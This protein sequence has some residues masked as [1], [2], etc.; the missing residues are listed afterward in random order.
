MQARASK[1]EKEG[2][3][4][5]LAG[6]AAIVTGGATGI[7][8]AVCLAFAREGAAVVVNYSKSQAEAE[9]TAQ[10]A[11]QVGGK[12]VTFQAD[13]ADE[14]RVKAMVAFAEQSFGRV[15]ILV[16][17][18]GYTQFI[19]HHQ[20]DRLSD[21]LWDR[22]FRVNVLGAFYA[23]RAVAPL[24][25]QQGEGC[26]INI[27]SIAGITGGGSSVPYAASKGALITLTKSMANALAPEIR[28]NAIAPGLIY[29]RWTAPYPER[30]EQI[31]QNTML[32]RLGTPEDIANAA[33]YL[34]CGGQWVTG[35]VLVI[36]G[37]RRT[38]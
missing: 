17:N 31:R 7:G 19:P 22:I 3:M 25:K 36:D 23:I 37:G 11:S 14:A 28:V 20:L 8:R 29:T 12:G 33:H 30:N 21:D 13:V 18:A 15:D 38:M 32:Q 16:N 26:I 24:M 9:E 34:A 35:Q 1:T 27:A 5:Q 6:K 4:P 10:A 2:P